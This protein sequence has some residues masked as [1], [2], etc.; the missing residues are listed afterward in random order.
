MIFPNYQNMIPFSQD[1]I[2]ANAAWFMPL[3]SILM[4][5]DLIWKGIALWKAGRNNQLRWFIALLA[6]N[7]VGILPIIYILFFQKKK[8]EKTP[9]GDYPDLIPKTEP[10]MGPSRTKNFKPKIKK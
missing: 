8:E 9:K 5:W 1:M 6:V 3:I 4:L 7:S 10:T 2:W